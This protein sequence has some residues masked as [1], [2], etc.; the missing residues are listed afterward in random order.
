MQPPSK[1]KVKTAVG[2]GSTPAHTP[3]HGGPTDPSHDENLRRG[4]I[5]TEIS[6]GT[7]IGIVS[8]FL[9]LIAAVPIGQAVMEKARGEETMLLDIFSRAPTRENLK[10]FEDDLDKA[11]YAKDFVQPRM[12]ALLTGLGRVGNKKAVVGR[13]GWLYYK[14]G[15][16]Y[17]GGPGFLEPDIIAMKIKAALDEGEPAGHPDPRPA[18]FAFADALAKRD[19]K[20]ILFP[21]PDKAML[22]PV[23]LHGR[24]ARASVLDVPRN[25]SWPAFVAEM[26][27]HGVTVFDPAPAALRQDEAPRFLLQDT[28]WTPEWMDAVARQLAGLIAR[29]AALAPAAGQTRATTR[30][31]VPLPV[32]RVGDVVDMLKLPDGQTIFA[33]QAITVGQVQDAGGAPWE[34]NPKADVLL[35]GDSFTNV[36]SLDSMGWGTSAGL[37]AHLSLAL[38]RDVDVIAQNDS[39][40]FATRQALARELG[41]GEDRLAGKRVV[42]WEFASRELAVGDWKPI[43]WSAATVATTGTGASGAH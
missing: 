13:Q 40:A 41:S 31:A 10:A 6:R 32:T 18:I 25:P 26:R 22:Q 38:A 23:Q 3:G 29:T 4:I 7:A 30:K 17:V 15:I 43:D 35:L 16:T 2:S 28:H 24:G 12:Q 34:P 14:P 33:P 36:F 42:V 1:V 27:G 19:I 21:V 37:G 20:L 9:V 11:S 39:G 8:F 5:H